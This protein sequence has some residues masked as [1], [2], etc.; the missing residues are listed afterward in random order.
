MKRRVVFHPLLFAL[1]PVLELYF[2]TRS[3]QPFSGTLRAMAAMLVLSSLLYLLWQRLLKDWDWA[4][5][6]ATLTLFALVYYGSI[7]QAFAEMG[8]IPG[9]E[10]HHSL[11]FPVW[12]A[13]LVL[14]GGPWVWRR[15]T[16]P[17]LV[18]QFLN[19]MAVVAVTLSTGRVIWQ[20]VTARPAPT[21]AVHASVG[22]ADEAVSLAGTQTP[23]IYYIILDGYARADVLQTLYHFDNTP[24]VDFLRARGF[25]VAEQSR[26]NYMQTF[27]SMSS[28]L[29]MGYLEGIP[30]DSL[31]RD[32]VTALI[33]GN[34]VRRLLQARGYRFITI[35]SGYPLTSI[36]DA[37]VFLSPDFGNVLSEF[38][39]LFLMRTSAMILLDAGVLHLPGAGYDAHR[40]VVEY[41]FAQLP[42]VPALPGPKFVYF[43]IVAP[44]PPFVL[45]RDGKPVTPA[46]PYA[47]LGDGNHFAGNPEEYR[48][49]YIEKLLYVN[50]QL[51]QVVDAI[52][53]ASSMPPI[54]ILQADH[55]PGAY[56]DWESVERSCV[57]ER[58]SILNAYYLPGQDAGAL[59]WPD[60]TPAN[61]FRVIFDA[62]FETQLGQLP[63]RVYYSRSHYPYDFTDVTASTLAPCVLPGK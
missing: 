61:S 50:R 19:L 25:Y 62:Y 41:A 33:A 8:I 35:N 51:Q 60:I 59:L 37:D 44:H 21:E 5:Y 43:H 48:A 32:A 57:W 23:D 28:A 45:D 4:A 3:F 26:S 1:Y 15:L 12:V 24:F 52:L 6:A 22:G 49:G 14:L 9:P 36:G 63:D 10:R 34:R 20:T 46:A 58:I 53:A 31:D 13:L 55:G 2:K 16:R 38:E 42:E 56:L 39:S 47:G 11:Y 7:Y 29:N 18:T 40:A 54:I 27:L 17:E 30:P